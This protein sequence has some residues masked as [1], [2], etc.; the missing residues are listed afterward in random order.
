M[1]SHSFEGGAAAL[2]FL[3]FTATYRRFRPWQTKLTV[4]QHASVFYYCPFIF[5]SL[6]SLFSTS[7]LEHPHYIILSTSPHCS[8]LSLPHYN[9]QCTPPPSHITVLNSLSHITPFTLMSFIPLLPLSY[10]TQMRTG[11]TAGLNDGQKLQAGDWLLGLPCILATNCLLVYFGQLP[12]SLQ[13]CPASC[14]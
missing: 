12:P 3:G 5:F 6:H 11:G 9:T 7:L 2:I 8:T 10:L 4:G 14:C 1:F 13:Y